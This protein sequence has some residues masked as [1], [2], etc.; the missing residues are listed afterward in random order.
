MEQKKYYLSGW[1][2]TAARI[3]S[4]LLDLVIKAGG[5]RVGKWSPFEQDEYYVVDESF[6][7]SRILRL[8]TLE[9]ARFILDETYYD[10][11]F[12]SNPLCDVSFRKQEKIE[13]DTISNGLAPCRL[14]F[15]WWAVPNKNEY[16]Y[17]TDE[18][19]SESAASLLNYLK[20]CM[21]SLDLSERNFVLERK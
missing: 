1:N 4:E 2:L 21:A 16:S 9:S 7:G 12:G 6:P 10:V 3:L 5:Y 11:E 14:E 20:Q 18:E 17:L 15:E 13:N 19:I 8:K